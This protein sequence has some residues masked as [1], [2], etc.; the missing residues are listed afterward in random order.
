AA[1]HRGHAADGRRS[2]GGVRAQAARL[3]T[4][5]QKKTTPAG[6]RRELLLH[7]WKLGPQAPV[8]G[9]DLAGHAPVENDTDEIVNIDDSCAVRLTPVE[10]DRDQIVNVA[11]AVAI[12][13]A[14]AHAAQS[15]DLNSIDSA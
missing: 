7:R 8:A 6:G 4:R 10:D 5:T 15:L 12:A 9:F 13:I 1:E 11:V 2:G 3:R 14:D